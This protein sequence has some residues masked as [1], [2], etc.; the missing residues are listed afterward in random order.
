MTACMELDAEPGPGPHS[1]SRDFHSAGLP[2]NPR[3]RV[4]NT[5]TAGGL[6]LDL[7]E[8][9]CMHRV[10]IEIRTEIQVIMLNYDANTI[11]AMAC[12]SAT[13]A[14]Y[15]KPEIPL[16]RER[17]SGARGPFFI[18]FSPPSAGRPSA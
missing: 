15:R 2:G 9:H 5:P 12:N 17:R 16:Q 14:A 6:F 4:N 18:K 11:A 3:L 10:C 1:K 13:C 7:P 8:L